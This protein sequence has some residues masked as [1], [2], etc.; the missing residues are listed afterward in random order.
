[1]AKRLTAKQAI[2]QY[3]RFCNG[4]TLTGVNKKYATDKNWANGVYYWMK[5]LY[6][7]L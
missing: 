7:N 1:M 4:E 3:C 5:H 6:N 2:K